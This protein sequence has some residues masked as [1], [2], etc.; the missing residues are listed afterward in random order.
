MSDRVRIGDRV[1]DVMT[2]DVAC[3]EAE[4]TLLELEQVLVDRHVSGAPVLDGARVVGVVSMMDVLFVLHQAEVDM[5]RLSAFYV[6]S[7][8]ISVPSLGQLITTSRPITGRL[9]DWRVRDVMTTD[10]LTVSS[11]DGVATAARRM[12]EHRVH[13]LLVIDDGRLVGIVSAFDLLPV[14]ARPPSPTTSPP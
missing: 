11:T 14:I 9:I 5:E 6:G 7:F 4:M 1:G 8:S 12:T 2:R 10:V 3:V 13:R